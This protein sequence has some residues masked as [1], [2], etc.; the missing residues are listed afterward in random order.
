MVERE[1]NNLLEAYVQ[2]VVL[3]LSPLE[4]ILFGSQA[5]GNTHQ[6][7]DIDVAVVIDNADNT[8]KNVIELETALFKL[9]RDIDLRIEPI[10][11]EQE[12]DKSGFLAHVRTTGKVLYRRAV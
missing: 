11:L 10:I 3:F 2:K 5:R 1:L 7:S 12:N 6:D 4:I 8:E 9:R